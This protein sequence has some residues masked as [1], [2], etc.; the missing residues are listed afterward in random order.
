L[1]DLNFPSIDWSDP[2]NPNIPSSS[3]ESDTMVQIHALIEL[4]DEFLLNQLISQP[5]RGDKTLDLTFTNLTSDLVDCEIIKIPNMSDHCLVDMTFPDL[6]VSN[7]EPIDQDTDINKTPLSKLNFYKADWDNIRAELSYVDWNNELKDQTVDEQLESMMRLV[8][9]ISEKYTPAKTGGTNKTSCR[10]NTVFYRERRALW[11]RRRRLIVRLQ[12]SKSTTYSDILNRNIETLQCKLRKAFEE[13]RE[14]EENKAI[15]NIVI[16]PKF[17]FAY[18]KKKGTV[19]SKVGPLY[20]ENEIISDPKEM[21]ECLQEQFK[22]VFSS[23]DQEKHI[24]DINEF[25][26]CDETPSGIQ[27]IS[28]SEEDIE[29]VITE[30]RS[31]A[32]SGDDGF[33]ALLLKNCKKELSVPL[34]ILWRNSLDSGVIPGLLKT[35]KISPIHKGGLKSVPKN[36]R[37]VALT[38]HLIKVMEKILRNAIVKYLEENNLMNDNQHGFRI[39]RSCLSQLL[40]HYDLLLEIIQSKKNADVVYLD[41]CKAFDVVDHHILLRK[42]K[43]LGITGKVGKWIY[44]FLTGRT[45]YVTVNGKPSNTAPVVSGVPQG[46][47]LGPILFLMMISDIDKDIIESITR[48][49]ADDTKVIQQICSSEDSKLLQ[50]SLDRIY[51][52]AVR[53]NMTFNDTKFNL[54]RY[55]SNLDN[56]NN[57]YKDPAGVNIKVEH[58]VKDLGVLMSDDLT[59]T[60]HI[61]KVSTTCRKLVYWILRTFHTR[62]QEPLL[63]LYKALIV[64]RL[65]YCS[66]LWSPYR[67]AEWKALE[68]VQ[69]T[70]TARISETKEQNYWQRLKSLNMYSVQ[71]RHERYS[72]LYIYKILENLAPNFTVNKIESKYNSR[73]G[74]LCKIPTL[75]NQQ[76]SSTVK[77]ARE[78]SLSIRGPRLFNSLPKCIRNVTGVSVNSFKRRLDKFLTQLPDE[79]TVD[80]YYGLR[81][82]T[83]N[84]LI[85]II[86]QTRMAT[87]EMDLHSF[88][89]VEEALL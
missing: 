26:D 15:S 71:R 49:F 68:S 60:D 27:D 33:S 88:N 86:P 22:S 36:Y 44:Q 50:N 87:A 30:I 23:P 25:F 3:S 64:P 5:T 82:Y 45:Q 85:D 46:S 39:F 53:N 55:G 42:L 35:S 80:G 52:W 34:H 72:V 54:M 43:S 76:C 32:A 12:R 17:F 58:N 28:F 7:T 11:R 9:E 48:T 24:D 78:A 83:S 19:Q 73:R 79:P 56:K 13:E 51:D 69:R 75:P 29:N 66:Q 41:F 16:N 4:T 1:G 62:S 40:D 89:S 63:K 47:V 67:Q 21:A 2:G 10:K 38:S 65:D 59:F 18:A 8:T 31:N 61:T 57:S 70:L 77:N 84:S 20:K 37:P 74:R 14:D 6:E 81:S